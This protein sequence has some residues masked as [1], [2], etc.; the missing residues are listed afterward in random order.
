MPYVKQGLELGRSFVQP[1]YWGKRSLDY[2]WFGIGAFLAKHPEYR[3][4]F[5]P[6]SISNQLPGS[7]REMLVHF[8]SREFAPTQAMAV[9]MSPFGLS[10]QQKAQL[11]NLYHHDDYQNNFKQLK[12]MLASMGAAV[13]TLYK[14]YGELCRADGVKFL[15]FGIDADFGDCIDGLVL[16]DT[17]KLK[18]KK[19]Q[20]Y[21]GVHLPEA[22][23]MFIA[24]EDDHDD[25]D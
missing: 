7:A 25:Q 4:L 3:Y 10:Q 5:G 17:H 22:E 24:P 16:V 9:S 19:Y 23:R 8:Y 11:D 15:A 21:I 14:Q 1:K 2:L 13:P 6:V 18:G 12:Q 20:R